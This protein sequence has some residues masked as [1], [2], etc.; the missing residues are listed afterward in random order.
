VYSLCEEKVERSR[1]VNMDFL[2]MKHTPFHHKMSLL[3]YLAFFAHFQQYSCNAFK[4][5]LELI[6]CHGCSFRL[7]Q[8][9]AKLGEQRP[10]SSA[11]AAA[12]GWNGAGKVPHCQLSSNG[13]VRADSN[14]P[15]IPF[16]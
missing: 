7:C 11:A 10:S 1:E 13:G 15:H 4:T 16:I 5:S 2:S 14:V 9:R 3:F 8:R 12:A 6:I